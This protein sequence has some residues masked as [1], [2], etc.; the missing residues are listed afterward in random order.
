MEGIFFNTCFGLL[1]VFVAH[2]AKGPGHNLKIRPVTVAIVA[3]SLHL[4]DHGVVLASQHKH[5]V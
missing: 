2:I 5:P 3:A 4:Q 1:A